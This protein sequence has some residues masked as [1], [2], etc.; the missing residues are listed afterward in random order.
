MEQEPVGQDQEDLS[1]HYKPLV[2]FNA[3]RTV[4]VTLLV[5]NSNGQRSSLHFDITCPGK[6][7]NHIGSD[8]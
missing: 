1:Q 7:T 3:Y 5:A 2:A 8:D 6:M 4:V